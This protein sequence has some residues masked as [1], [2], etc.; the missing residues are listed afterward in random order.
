[1][2]D[3]ANR[4]LG[5]ALADEVLRRGTTRAEAARTLGTSGANVSRWISGTQIPTPQHHPALQRFL[6]VDRARFALLMLS[7]QEQLWVKRH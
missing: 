3:D 7:A 1:M 2:A 4:T 5:E 6:G